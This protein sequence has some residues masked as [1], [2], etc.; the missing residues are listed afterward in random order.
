MYEAVLHD[1]GENL[2]TASSAR[3]A[4]QQLLKTEVAVVLVDVCMPELDGFQLA[5][6]IRDVHVFDRPR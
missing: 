1:L 3:E 4:L 5:A 2:L 6:M